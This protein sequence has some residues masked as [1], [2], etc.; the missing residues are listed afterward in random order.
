[1][2][3][4]LAL[5]IKIV[6]KVPHLLDIEAVQKALGKVGLQILKQHF[7]RAAELLDILF[8]EEVKPTTSQSRP[9]RM[10]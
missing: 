1:M 3:E 8:P 4:A 6:E 2:S 7:P 10:Q 9:S 5:L